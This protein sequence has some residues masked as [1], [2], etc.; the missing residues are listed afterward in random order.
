[1]TG[2]LIILLIGLLVIGVPVTVGI[3]VHMKTNYY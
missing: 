3:G 1:M 2:V